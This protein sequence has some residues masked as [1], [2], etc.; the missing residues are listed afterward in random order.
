MKTDSNGRKC[1]L[2]VENGLMKTILVQN[3]EAYLCRRV[4]GTDVKENEYMLVPKIHTESKFPPA[5]LFDLC[6]WLE[7][8][9][10]ASDTLYVNLTDE[11]GRLLP[12]DHIHLIVRTD[13]RK[14]GM[15]GL[16]K[17]CDQLEAGE[18]TLQARISELEL[19]VNALQNQLSAARR[20]AGLQLTGY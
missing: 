19:E 18:A 17:L 13:G 14:L 11:G 10:V 9:G 8:I 6:S 15:N 1:P 3:D 12:H 20:R 2:C 4:E 5:W 16:I 7:V